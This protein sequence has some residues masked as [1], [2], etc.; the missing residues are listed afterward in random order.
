[1]NQEAHTASTQIPLQPMF[2][3]RTIDSVALLRMSAVMSVAVIRL[4]NWR[5]GSHD[6]DQNDRG[7]M[8]GRALNCGPISV[9]VGC[10]GGGLP[11]GGCAV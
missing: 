7:R 4:A 9:G 6:D 2:A 8:S 1:M 5:L 10:R 3:S 11:E